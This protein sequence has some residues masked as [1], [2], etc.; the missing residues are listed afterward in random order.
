MMS[1]QCVAV[2]GYIAPITLE[3]CGRR[4][5]TDK[6]TRKCRRGAMKSSY[7]SVIALDES[8]HMLALSFNRVRE[9]G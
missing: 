7:A 8:P 6:E 5:D 3:A 9:V 1:R 2:L 4:G